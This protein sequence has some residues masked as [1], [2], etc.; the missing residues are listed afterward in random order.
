MVEVIQ[1]EDLQVQ[2][3]G[4]VSRVALERSSNLTDRTPQPTGAEVVGVASDGV[5]PA[6]EF[7]LSGADAG[8]DGDRLDDLRRVPTDRL[9]GPIHVV[10]HRRR[11]ARGRHRNVVLVGESGGDGRRALGTPPA[12]DDGRTGSLPRLGQGRGVFQLEMTAREAVRLARRRAPEAGDDLELFLQPIEA[13]LHRRERDSVGAVLLL[14]PTRSDAELD[15]TAGHGVDGGDGDGKRSGKAKGGG[16]EHG[17][18]ADALGV[19]GQSGEGDPRVARPRKAADLTHLQVVVRAEEGV[20]AQLLGQL[21]DGEKLVVGGALLGLGED[22]EVHKA[23]TLPRGDPPSK[24]GPTD[25]VSG[26]VRRRT[27]AARW[28]RRPGRSARRRSGGPH[29]SGRPT[30]RPPGRRQGPRR[31]GRGTHASP[32]RPERPCPAVQRC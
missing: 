12:D 1:V 29:A 25:W 32:P 10:E 24:D 23:A 2:P 18:E 21:G 30:G 7:G 17:P 9:A 22:S 8:N 15:T 6:P 13:L 20:E 28:S 27:P 16:G 26:R 19:P 31:A 4:T 11:R 14:I 5:G 3:G